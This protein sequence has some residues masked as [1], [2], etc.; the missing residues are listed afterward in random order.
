[1]NMKKK[2][3]INENQLELIVNK[4]LTEKM[5][6]PNNILESAEDLYEIISKYLNSIKH[7]SD[8]YKTILNV[9][10]PIEDL[11]I[12]SV[13]LTIGVNEIGEYD[14]KAEIASMGVANPFSFNR[15]VMMKVNEKDTQL[16]LIIE[17]IVSDDWDVSELYDRFVKN[18]VETIS[19][20]AHELKHKYDKSKKE[21]DLIG[22]DAE[23][24][25]FSQQN[26]NFGIPVI[27]NFMRYSYFIN[28][29]EGLV[30]PTEVASRI[31]NLNISKDKFLEF[32]QN[33]KTYKEL[34]D[35][36]NFTFD[37]LIRQMGEQMDSV[38]N[39]LK[40]I[41]GYNENMDPETKIN[42]VLRVVYISLVNGKIDI[43]DR[44]TSNYNP[45]SS[46][47]KMLGLNIDNSSEEMDNVRRKFIN[48]VSKYENNYI[49]FFKDE[50]ERF[51]YDATKMIKKL[52]KLYD[53][54]K[55]NEEMNE[56]II[57]WDLHQQL[58]EKKY[59][60]RK[61]ETELKFKR[62]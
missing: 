29:I 20:L 30:R 17:Y 47:A 8:N 42:K 7:K 41:D 36:K 51:G 25:T 4:L 49:Q 12:T 33:D 6:V 21:F 58:M 44:M 11:I 54:A 34:M 45:L 1:M 15:K 60:K 62:K 16:D 59:G 13:M 14:G 32:L 2:L 61:I 37:Y 24:Q 56:S 3:I 50:C 53:M 10:L 27:N 22:K 57:D 39:L 9:N 26:L 31:K 55:D 43:F 19:I 23:Y 40:H 46:F 48:Y 28:N 35:I 52:G 5:G 18:K 38:D